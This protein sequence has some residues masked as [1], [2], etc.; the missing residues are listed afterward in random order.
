MSELYT[1]TLI[2]RSFSAAQYWGIGLSKL[3]K[4]DGVIFTTFT[5]ED[6]KKVSY[7]GNDDADLINLLS[8]IDSSS[9]ALVF[10]EQGSNK[11]KV[12]WRALPGIDVSKLALTFGGG[13]HPA[14]SG[15]EISGG[16]LDIQEKVLSATTEFLKKYDNKTRV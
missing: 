7:S 5:L 11:V 12:S 9:I 2:R 13:G 15:A 3:Q 10:V 6:R 14:A 8:S 16:I 4:K 1:K